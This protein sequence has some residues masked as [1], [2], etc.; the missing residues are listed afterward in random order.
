MKYILMYDLR[1]EFR[2]EKMACVLK[3]SR[4]GTILASENAGWCRVSKLMRENNILPKTAKNFKA[5]TS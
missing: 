3:C 4:S 2:V 5:T 1:R